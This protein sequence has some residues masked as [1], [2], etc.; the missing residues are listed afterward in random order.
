MHTGIL[1][2]WYRF[3]TLII[4]WGNCFSECFTVSN[5]V[6]QGSVLSPYLFC[7]YVDIIS[8]RLN[9]TKIGCK[10]KELIV[11]HLFHADDLCLVTSSSRGLQFY[12]KGKRKV[13]FL[14]GTSPVTFV[15]CA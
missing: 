2:Y 3:Q 9:K 14:L 5:G 11:N 7:V 8:E 10:I 1:V 6:R 12:L 15:K 13:G 4:K